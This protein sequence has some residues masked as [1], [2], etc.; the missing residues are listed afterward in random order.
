MIIS[1]SI[2]KLSAEQKFMC[3]VL[4][5][6][7]GNYLY[8]LALGRI[9]GPEL[10]ADAA[11]LI[12]FLL[13]VSF[14]AMTFQLAT[15]KFSVL[16]EKEVFTNFV[17]ISYKYA[18]IAGIALGVALIVFAKDLQHMFNTQTHFMFVFF[19]LGIPVYFIMSVNRG[20]LQGKNKFDDLAKT[21]QGEM[22]SRL[23][24]TLVLLYV[25]SSVQS[26]I[27]IAIGL[28]VSFVIGLYP[29]KT[30]KENLIKKATL[31][32]KDSKRVIRFFVLTA[33]YECTQIIINN[34][35]ILLVKHYFEEY[36]A[37]LYASLALIGRVVY[38]VAWMFVMLLLPKVVQKQKDGEEHT[39]ILFRY[40][41][42]IT[43]LAIA[44]VSGCYLFPETVIKLLFGSEY[45][46]IAPLLWKYAI[47][48]SLF[49]IS[50][51]FAY[52]FLS[53]DR[54]IP[55][56]LSGILGI[57]QIVLVVLFHSSLTQVVTM[58]IIAMAVLLVVQGIYFFRFGR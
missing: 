37:G 25:L 18:S 10:F 36:D 26:S 45:I 55:V 57:S 38:F 48:T 46:F 53:L 35:D 15:A 54:Y 50:N 19:G 43:I 23:I 47:A 8:N 20:I 32:P 30:K 52:Y 7:A 6:N 4:I 51:I 21:Y 44:I 41:G 12:T 13:I 22:I 42:Y 1:T 58:Q 39:S 5:V 31:C 56:L 9:L 40:V 16:F 33:F 29:F 28:V 14:I 3:S 11:L 34:S 2:S 17:A 49:A 24:I 27:I